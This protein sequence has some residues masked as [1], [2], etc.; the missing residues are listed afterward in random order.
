MILNPSQNTLAQH[1]QHFNK[2]IPKLH[3]HNILKIKKT[4]LNF[5]IDPYNILQIRL[6]EFLS[7]SG[8]NLVFKLE[9]V[10]E[11]EL[12]VCEGEEEQLSGGGK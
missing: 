10:E 2:L 7:E 11:W 9:F 8:R 5:Q 12:G 3:N 1:T 6:A 4:N